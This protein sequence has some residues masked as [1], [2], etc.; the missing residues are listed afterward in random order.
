ME[1]AQKQLWREFNLAERNPA[2]GG[3]ILYCL[4]YSKEHLEAQ[5]EAVIKAIRGMRMSI[6]DVGE[7]RL[8]LDLSFIPEDNKKTAC[9]L[10]EELSVVNEALEYNASGFGNN[11][12][13]P[14]LSRGLMDTYFQMLTKSNPADTYNFISM[15]IP[16]I[17]R[18]LRISEAQG[19]N[20]TTKE[21]KAIQ[22]LQDFAKSQTRRMGNTSKYVIFG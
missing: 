8:E 21:R 2:Q 18:D 3:G 1:E 7:S 15:A 12:S 4:R 11:K 14:E 9:A 22:E 16:E 19:K 10:L 6:R 13:I 5:Q 20:F 17:V